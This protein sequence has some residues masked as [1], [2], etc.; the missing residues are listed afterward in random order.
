M[1]MHMIHFPSEN[2]I[3]GFPDDFLAIIW[4]I[5]FIF[6]I[7]EIFKIIKERKFS[8]PTLVIKE[9]DFNEKNNEVIKIIWRK[10]WLL[11]FILTKL[12]VKNKYTFLVQKEESQLSLE[13]KWINWI[14]KLNIN[15]DAISFIETSFFNDITFFI[16]LEII[17][18]FLFLFSTIMMIWLFI[19]IF[20]FIYFFLS[21]WIRI[22]FATNWGKTLILNYSPSIIEWVWLN[23]EKANKIEKI[24][25]ELR[26]EQAKK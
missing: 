4:I 22:K 17:A 7:L 6:I 19:G 1:W 23:I 24:I 15:F 16:F 10:S 3:P 26:N 12:K 8:T 21:K 9:I 14:S 5:F 25:S 11:N 13:V 18:L 20:G 2:L